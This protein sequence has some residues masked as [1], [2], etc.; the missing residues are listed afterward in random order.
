MKTIRTFALSFGAALLFGSFLAPGRADILYVANEVNDT[1]EKFSSTGSDLGIFARHP[2][3][4]AAAFGLAFDSSANLF[5]AYA[6]LPTNL[7]KFSATGAYLF[8]FAPGLGYIQGVA[9]DRAG[10]LYVANTTGNSIEKFSTAGTDLGTFASSGLSE[11]R[12]IAFDSAGNLYAANS[13]NNAIVKFSPTG[14]NLGTF[15]SAPSARLSYPF[16]LAFDAA[17]NLYVASLSLNQVEKFS[18]TGTDLGTFASSG[19]SSPEGLAFDST[20]NLYVA[21]QGGSTIQKFTPSGVGSLFASNGVSGPTFLAFT[22]DTGKPLPLPP[23]VAATAARIAIVPPFV[24]GQALLRVT[25]MP[26]TNYTVQAATNLDSSAASW[27]SLVT[28]NSQTGTFDFLDAHAT[29]PTRFY[30]AAQ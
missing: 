14:T 23:N 26:G 20:G 12:G 3:A 25:G 4:G 18:P 27:V 8:S 19:L 15:A 22:D 10:N 1:I 6:N 5:V 2:L 9:L 7:S 17:G 13:G 29:N 28:S 11:P 16:G 21:N 30:R 24:A